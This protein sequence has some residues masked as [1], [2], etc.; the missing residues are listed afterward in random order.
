MFTEMREYIGFD[1]I[2]KDPV[3]NQEYPA[4]P[5]SLKV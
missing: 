4:A 1:K 3:E 5:L 2:H